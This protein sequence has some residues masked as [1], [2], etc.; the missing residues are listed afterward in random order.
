MRKIIH[1]DCDSFYASVEMRDDPTLVELPIAVGGRPGQRGVVATCNYNARAFGVHSAMPMAQALRACPDLVVLP[2]NMKKYKA[3]SAKVQAIFH[4]YTELVEPLSLDEAFLDVS[5]STLSRGSATLIAKEIRQRVR[6]EVGI[7][8]SAGIAPNK[9]LAK[10]ASDWNKPDGQ[11]TITPDEIED[12]VVC[13]PV[14]KL[15]GVGTVTAKRMRDLGVLTCGDLQKQTITDL[16]RHFG[17]FGVRLFELCR[18][19]DERS[20]KTHRQRKSLSSE[21]T[22]ATDLPNLQACLGA[23][24]EL[25]DDL[26]TRIERTR[27]R[28]LIT[29]RIIK[30]RFAGFE[31]TT[32]ASIGYG[33]EFDD[34]KM[35]LQTAWQRQGKPVRLL[36]VGVKLTSADSASQLGLFS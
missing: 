5:D 10:I 15:F 23:L 12:F 11:F 8:I 14:Q 19:I 33:T 36:G 30:V 35:L 22:Y 9:F 20:V 6:R 31:T 4:E 2:T 21:R 25:V 29:Q 32:H 3:E 7:T 28:A 34:Y 27:C 24:Q 13:L 1:C 26:E 17:K 16:T 18:G